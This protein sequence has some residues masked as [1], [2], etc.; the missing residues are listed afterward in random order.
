MEFKDCSPK[1]FYTLSRVPRRL[2]WRARCAV[3]NLQVRLIYSKPITADNGKMWHFNLQVQRWPHS[4]CSHSSSP[5][6]FCKLGKDACEVVVFFLFQKKF[7]RPAKNRLTTHWWVVTHSLG[8]NGLATSLP[9]TLFLFYSR[10]QEEWWRR[11]D[12]HLRCSGLS[13]H[14][15]CPGHDLLPPAPTLSRGYLRTMTS[16]LSSKWQN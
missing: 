4:I 2:N 3:R 6:Y 7:P 5:T 11:T 14:H 1:P 16:S 13:Q 12:H 8:N 15:R 9:H 10:K